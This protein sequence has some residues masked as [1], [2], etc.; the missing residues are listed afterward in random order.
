MTH[1]I[2]K[3]HALYT[4]KSRAKETVHKAQSTSAS[5]MRVVKDSKPGFVVAVEK[6]VVVRVRGYGAQRKHGPARVSAAGQPRFHFK[7]RVL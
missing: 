4:V 2:V 5:F 3:G 1:Q 6:R 7:N